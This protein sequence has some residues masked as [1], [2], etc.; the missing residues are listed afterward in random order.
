MGKLSK[1]KG[2]GESTKKRILWLHTQPEHYF[3]C[4]MDD[5]ARGS[6]YEVPGMPTTPVPHFEYIA[7]FAARGPGWYQENQPKVAQTVFLHTIEGGEGRT[8]GFREKY[9]VNWQED[10]LP[11]KFDA[12]IVSGYAWR[13]QRELI[14]ACH[15]RG[16][17]VVMWSDS[18]LRSEHG[19]GWK[20]RLKR[21]LKKRFLRRV[22]ESVDHLMT[23]NQLGV[24]YWRYY[25]APRRKITVCPYYADYARIDAARLAPRAEV[26]GRIG[27]PAETRM[28][29]SAA[30]LVEAKG[31][32]RM[33]RGV[34]GK[35]GLARY[36]YV[37]VI[38]GVGPLEHQLKALAGP[39]LGKSIRFIGFQQP[40]DN[41]ALM[42]H[43][44]L[45]ALP[46]L[47]EPHGI[48]VAEAL[49]AGTPVLASHVVGAA[50]DLVRHGV[51]GTIIHWDRI[52]DWDGKWRW[53]FG[54]SETLPSLRAGARPAFEEWYRRTSPI[55]VVPEVMSRLLKS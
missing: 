49:A 24:A 4:M 55:R 37:Y 11:L 2:M 43:A 6:G 31:L 17:P 22:I 41:F 54:N 8:P 3:N 46:S 51:N 29:F 34:A 13:T 20:Q 10:L 1:L 21:G 14:D 44:D 9:H 45:L 47:Y 52:A 30:R 5:L 28:I 38:A 48:V 33:I 53:L 25:G 39:E 40:A 42:A 12:A 23:A 18:N 36:G 16:I 26:L 32:D 27:L 15:R 19:R 7:A 50:H 35:S